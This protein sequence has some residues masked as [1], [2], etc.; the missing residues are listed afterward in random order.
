MVK[1]LKKN[2]IVLLCFFP[3][4]ICILVLKLQ[5]KLKRKTNNNPLDRFKSY[6]VF[7]GEDIRRL[8]KLWW[9]WKLLDKVWNLS[10]VS[11]LFVPSQKPL[12][13]G[14]GRNA[15]DQCINPLT[16][17]LLIALQVVRTWFEFYSRE[18]MGSSSPPLP[19]LSTVISFLQI[20]LYRIK[21]KVSYF[22]LFSAFGFAIVCSRYNDDIM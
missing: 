12:I 5:G 11:I 17:P 19:L 22:M 2:D 16:R 1:E 4:R 8:W 14:F 13:Y 18:C 7:A 3:Y 15:H 10:E 21:T 6:I 9:W 20:I